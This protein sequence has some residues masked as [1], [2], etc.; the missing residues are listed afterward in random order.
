MRHRNTRDRVVGGVA[1][2]ALMPCAK[3]KQTDLPCVCV[4]VHHHHNADPLYTVPQ[5]ALP[6]QNLEHLPLPTHCYSP[7]ALYRLSPPPRYT[8]PHPHPLPSQGIV[9][10]CAT[11][12]MFGLCYLEL[13]FILQSFDEIS[14]RVHTLLVASFECPPP[15]LWNRVMDAV[16]RGY[17]FC[18][19]WFQT[20]YIV[21]Y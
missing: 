10:T 3:Q 12:P 15:S 5:C 20:P 11:T 17:S 19:P 4:T 9:Y 14:T 7:F 13:H 8:S 18:V 16:C 6:W 1:W 21:F 2:Q